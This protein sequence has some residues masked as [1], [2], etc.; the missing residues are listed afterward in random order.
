[1]H[2]NLAIYSRGFGYRVN[3]G[4]RSPPP[5]FQHYTVSQKNVTI[6]SCYNFD[7]HESIVI[8]FG[9][10]IP[11]KV[12]NKIYF[13]FPPHLTT[14]VLYYCTA[15]LSPVAGLIYS[16]LLLITDAHDDVWLPKP[17]SQLS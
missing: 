17:R 10:N 1:V 4:V 6:L 16:V 14:V 3:S 11:E 13:T 9:K 12:S 2:L 15:R 8:I 5:N 7:T